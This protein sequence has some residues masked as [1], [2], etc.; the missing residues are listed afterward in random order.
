MIDGE[1]DPLGFVGAEL[2]GRGALV[3]RGEREALVMLPAAVATRLALPEVFTLVEAARPGAIGCGLGAPLLDL[4]TTE[5]RS[6]VPVAAVTWSAEAP[7]AAVAERVAARLVVRNG[8]ADVL[9][10]GTAVATYVVG[11]FGW[12]AEA[13]DRYQGMVTLIAHGA[14]GGE[15]DDAATAGLQRMV[16]GDDPRGEAGPMIG[17]VGAGLRGLADRLPRSIGAR[18]DEVGAAVGRRAERERSRIDDY[19]RSLI[20]EARRPR[21]K[22]ARGAIT[23][24]VAALEA[25]HAAK[26]RDL[27]TRYALRVKLEPIALIAIATRVAEV[28]VR[29]RRR[30]G[31]RELAL[32]LPPTA[33]TFDALA[34]AACA[35]TTRAPVLCDDALHILCEACAPEVGGRPRCPACLRPAV[36]PR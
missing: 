20:A 18:L 11:V 4:L 14:S 35:A 19:F 6:R 15:P 31:E 13:D 21:G 34:C 23:A 16:S 5:V 8:V 32:H 26:L 24:R 9:G 29:L 22:V 7:R 25:E 17:E 27:A 28:R 30:K 12:S 36:R 10:T 1:L 3:D 33:R 2:T